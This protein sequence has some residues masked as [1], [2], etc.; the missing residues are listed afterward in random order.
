MQYVQWPI[1]LALPFERLRKTVVACDG[2]DDLT[3]IGHVAQIINSIVSIPAFA[4]DSSSTAHSSRRSIRVRMDAFRQLSSRILPSTITADII[5][6]IL[7]A[8][9]HVR[10]IADL[11]ARLGHSPSALRYHWR[12]DVQSRY[13]IALHRFVRWG[14]LLR[15]L[16]QLEAGHD[17]LDIAVCLGVDESTLYRDLATLLGLPHRKHTAYS[18]QKGIE[19]LLTEFG[20]D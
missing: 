5:K 9:E 20:C 11:A 6:E 4:M 14:R 15:V 12:R 10:S 16:E 1:V 18:E 19:R 13:T 2:A 8:A 7:C 17:I 3:D